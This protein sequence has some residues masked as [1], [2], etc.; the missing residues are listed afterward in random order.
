MK[1][2]GKGSDEK[3]WRKKGR[4]REEKKWWGWN[5]ERGERERE[6][7]RERGRMAVRVGWTR[8]SD[9]LDQPAYS[10]VSRSIDGMD[11][12]DST[13]RCGAQGLLASGL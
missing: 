3:C 13:S 6:R 8:V 7:E 10:V 5:E 9:G 2:N 1:I 4:E 11:G 12:V